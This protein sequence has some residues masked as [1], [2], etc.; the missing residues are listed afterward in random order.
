MC[1]REQIEHMGNDELT[2][3]LVLVKDE[4]VIRFFD[5]VTKE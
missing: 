1:S 2:E 3:L 4:M 5:Q